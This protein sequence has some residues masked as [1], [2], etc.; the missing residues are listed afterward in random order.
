[1]K[2]LHDAVHKQLLGLSVNPSELDNVITPALAIY[3]EF[4]TANVQVMQK[5]LKGHLELWQPHVKTSKLAKTMRQLTA[6]GVTHFK[7][8]TTLE[9]LTACEAGAEEVLFS[10]PA[11]GPR[12]RRIREIAFSS[13]GTRIFATVENVAQIDQWKGSNVGL[14]IDVNPGMDRTGI[15]LSARQEIVK[16]AAGMAESGVSFAGLHCYEGHARQPDLTGR[17]ATLFPVYEALTALVRTLENA[18]LSM[19][20]VVT[21]GTPALPCVLAFQ[22]T[23]REAFLHRISPGTVVYGDLTSA[24]QLPSEWGFRLAAIVISRVISRPAPGI[25][26]CDA[27]H[28]VMSADLG[29]PNCIVLGHPEFEPLGPSEEHMPIR[30][31]E[32]EPIPEI[33]TILYLA[34]KHICPTVNNFDE[35]LWVEG[36]RV[37][38][39]AE[40]TARGRESPLPSPVHE[41]SPVHE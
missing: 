19:N 10:Y 23:C 12:A 9:L 1:M 22:E 35:A 27:G 4:I 28:K 5:L 31:P 11:D 24:E 13:L 2:Q 6:L 18:G 30:V 41:R 40:V 3:P 21:S 29:V 16:L 25:I 32:G 37:L 26:T 7:C 38:E 15:A 20:C 14:Y 36:G 39:V 17:K 33:G 8:A 34:P